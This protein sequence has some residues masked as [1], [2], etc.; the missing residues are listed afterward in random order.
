MYNV[1][2][3]HDIK[4][5]EWIPIKMYPKVGLTHVWVIGKYQMLGLDEG[6]EN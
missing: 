2:T 5:T 6:N 1:H 4:L 3:Y